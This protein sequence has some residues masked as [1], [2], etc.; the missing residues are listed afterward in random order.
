[1]ASPT[2]VTGNQNKVREFSEIL[3]IKLNARDLELEEIQSLD[4]DK[5]ALKKAE[6]A[7]SQL[8]QPVVVEDS[9]LAIEAWKGLPGAL[10]VWFT[11]E[12]VGVDG[13]LKMLKEE[14]NRTAEV[15]I[16]IG[17]CAERGAKVFSATTRGL[18]T[19]EQKGE[20]GWEWDRIFQPEGF[21]KTYAEMS[22][23]EKNRVST[24]KEALEKLKEFLNEKH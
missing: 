15:K 23:E 9:S 14:T 10:I 12:T 24:R 7:Y 21:E 2:L 5:V 18:I 13:L 4:P 17:Y 20:N 3:E 22:P 16:S 8:K 11:K 6:A 1:M 19:L